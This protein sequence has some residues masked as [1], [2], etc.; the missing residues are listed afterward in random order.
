MHAASLRLPPVAQCCE[1]SEHTATWLCA[2][3]H[4]KTLSSP[5]HRERYKEILDDSLREI[6]LN[7]NRDLIQ[8]IR[9]GN[10]LSMRI[11]AKKI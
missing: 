7:A 6:I 9:S 1:F 3:D 10:Q 2:Q 5:V 4:H 11:R 8:N